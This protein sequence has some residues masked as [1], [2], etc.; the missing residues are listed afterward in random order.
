MP[1]TVLS[2]KGQIIIPKAL[3]TARRWG[4]GTQLE[5]HDTP[6]GVLLRPAEATAKTSLASGLAAI[7]RRVGYQGPAVSLQ[8]MDA[9]VQREAALRAGTAA[10]P[11]KAARKTVR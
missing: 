6:E 3:R 4:P 5:V 8:Q 1:T 11:Q 7:R 10:A 9:A 2:S